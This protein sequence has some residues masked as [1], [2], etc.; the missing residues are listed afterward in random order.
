[1][2]LTELGDE[3]VGFIEVIYIIFNLCLCDYI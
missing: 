2:I 3:P 1:M